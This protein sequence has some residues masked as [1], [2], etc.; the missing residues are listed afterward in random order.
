MLYPA[1]QPRG[2]PPASPPPLRPTP[3]GSAAGLSGAVPSAVCR[4]DV[5]GSAAGKAPQTPV[6]NPLL[7]EKPQ[8]SPRGRRWPEPFALTRLLCV[9]AGG[10]SPGSGAAIVVTDAGGEK[11]Q[12][13]SS[14]PAHYSLRER[15]LAPQS[16]CLMSLAQRRASINPQ[17]PRLGLDKCKASE[18]K[19]KQVKS[20]PS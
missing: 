7:P 2:E 1:P 18:L 9:R 19:Q 17:A 20:E 10:C 13:G 11:F 3:R 12:S 4:G 5:R 15:P 8:P 16:C 6:I 14:C